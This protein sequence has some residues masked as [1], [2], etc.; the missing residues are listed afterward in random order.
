[1]DFSQTANGTPGSVEDGAAAGTVGKSCAFDGVA[2]ATELA[3]DAA[4]ETLCASIGTQA[5]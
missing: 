4:V 2:T 3:A 5:V 1:M